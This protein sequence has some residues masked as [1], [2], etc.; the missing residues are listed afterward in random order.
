MTNKKANECASCCGG[1]SL[2]KTV[3]T[4]LGVPLL[5]ILFH[6]IYVLKF[7]EVPPT[8][9]GSGS[10]FDKIA[11]RYDITNRFLALNLDTSWRRLMVNEVLKNVS[12]ESDQKIKILD[13]ATGTA[14]VAILL[15]NQA[16]SRNT[17]GGEVKITGVDP[18]NNMISIGKEKVKSLDLSQQIQLQIGDARNLKEL[19]DSSFHGATMAFGIRN[20]PEKELA[21]CEMH[22]VLM[23][24]TKSDKGS[25][26]AILEFSEPDEESGILGY[27]F[28]RPFIRHVVPVIGAALSGAPREYMHLQNSIKEFP[29]P[30]D[31]VSLMENLNCNYGWRKKEKGNFR[32]DNLHQLNFGSVQLYVAT[33]V[34]N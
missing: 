2:L 23:K 6:T 19:S 5:A 1:V 12:S 14:D 33:P 28:A 24:E 34:F 32:V 20:V 26:L 22:R 21:L 16:N 13:L 18:S 31:F 8:D 15:A 9:F 10:M 17:S 25:K 7:T 4:V 11:H 3:G 30:T 29:T 27:Y